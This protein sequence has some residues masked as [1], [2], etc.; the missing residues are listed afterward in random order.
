MEIVSSNVLV[1]SSFKRNDINMV[2]VFVTRRKDHKTVMSCDRSSH[3]H[4]VMCL[5]KQ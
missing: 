3:K 2:V 1:W 4:N 5:T